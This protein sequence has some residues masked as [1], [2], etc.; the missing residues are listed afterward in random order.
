MSAEFEQV[1]LDALEDLREG[2]AEPIERYLELVPKSK[3]AQLADLLAM[4]FAS[5]RGPAS[6]E[7]NSQSYERVLAAIDR[8]N[9]SQGEAGILPALLSELRRTR[10]LRRQDVTRELSEH[11]K[12][13][14]KGV[15]QFE[16]EY[17]RLET[18]QLHGALL[19]KRLLQALSDL[20]RIDL[21]DLVSASLPLPQAHPTR[22]AQAFARSGGTVRASYRAS[23]GE[24]KPLDPLVQKLFYG[25]PDA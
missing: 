4:Y 1:F 5:R 21:D 12:L 18:G 6:R 20:F 2:R 24:E 17:H 25:G 19:S 14:D 23:S 9:E 7:V 10:R 22:E 11:F 3:R 13:S 8:L 16:R 15:V